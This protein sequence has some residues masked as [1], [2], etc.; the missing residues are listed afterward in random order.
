MASC[1]I[2]ARIACYLSPEKRVWILPFLIV[3]DTI[4]F[5]ARFLIL[6][7]MT[8]LALKALGWSSSWIL[9]SLVNVI[10]A[11]F[12]AFFI[13]K[14]LSCIHLSVPLE[15]NKRTVQEEIQ[16]AAPSEEPHAHPA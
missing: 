7:A 2:L 5:T 4:E 6:S 14:F 8:S 15:H 3:V 10:I 13:S 9:V 16:N 1:L 12:I 11:R